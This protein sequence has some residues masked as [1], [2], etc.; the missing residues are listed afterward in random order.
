MKYLDLA[1]VLR[2]H[3]RLI[4][5]YGGSFGVLSQAALESSLAAPQQSMFGEELYPDLASKASILFYLLVKNHGFMD[6]NKR[7]AF[8]CLLRLLELNG[9]VLNATDDQLYQLTIDVVT[10]VVGKEQLADWVRLHAVKRTS[11]LIQK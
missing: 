7:T 9:F 10:S 1:E 2:I 3:D 4:A 6:G 5:Q 11:I 8:A